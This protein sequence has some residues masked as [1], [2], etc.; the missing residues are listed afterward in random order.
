MEA[1]K[2]LRNE[3]AR[4]VDNI[5]AGNSN[6][7]E[8][9]LSHVVETVQHYSDKTRYCTKYE[10]CQYLRG[11]SRATFDNLVAEGKLPKGEKRHQGDNNLFWKLK[12]LE[13]YRKT[14]GSK[15]S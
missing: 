10:A 15:R 7:D 8:E 4:V 5:D 11:I 6:M 1:I 14:M 12:D 3:L 2:V 13:A 9:E